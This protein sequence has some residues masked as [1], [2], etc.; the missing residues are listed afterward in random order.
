VI[1]DLH[2]DGL[3]IID[4]IKVIREL[5][6][7]GLKEANNLVSKHPAWAKIVEQSKPVQSIFADVFASSSVEEYKER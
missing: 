4:V 1:A 6:S 5:Y 2:S 3:T 7:L